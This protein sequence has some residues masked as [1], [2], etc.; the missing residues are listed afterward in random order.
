MVF[1]VIA[2][3][4]LLV[5]VVIY[6]LPMCFMHP[7]PSGK[8][9]GTDMIAV[10]NRI[11][12]LFFIPSGEDWIVIDAG[13]DA[14]AVKREMELMAIDGQRVKSVFLTHTDYDHVASVV[15]FPNAAIYMSAQEKQMIDG[16]VCRQF[17]K[18]NSLPALRDSNKMIYLPDNTVVEFGEHKV[19]II[20]AAGH[21]KGSAM[22]A[23]DEKYLF[24]GD[25][26]KKADGHIA[27]H[28]YTMDRKQAQET[29]YN[30][31]D[32]LQKYEKVFTA[33]YGIISAY[34]D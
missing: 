6:I 17:F 15:L 26:F 33:H 25:A 19:R 29:I 7:L 18:K 9:E 24:T 1:V 2:G 23:V 10:K 13:S 32:E 28:P 3:V 34:G 14:K 4:A 12:N 20:W 27:V 11:N 21:T 5:M 16:S 30:I 31:K 8:I 22:Y